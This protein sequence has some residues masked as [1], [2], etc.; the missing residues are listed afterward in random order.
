[1]DFTMSVGSES[2]FERGL[3]NKE[4]DFAT[5]TTKQQQNAT[6]SVAFAYFHGWC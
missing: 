6:L 1:M 2:P 3:M 5:T 4:P